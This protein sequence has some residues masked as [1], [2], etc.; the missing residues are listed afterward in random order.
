MS[1]ERHNRVMKNVNELAARRISMRNAVA[2]IVR[3]DVSIECYADIMSAS[4]KY[5]E[6]IYT[7]EKEWMGRLKDIDS[8]IV[9]NRS[10][11]KK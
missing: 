4:N 6:D 1:I 3:L 7:R 8:G 11:K 5:C 2:L 9:S 10:E